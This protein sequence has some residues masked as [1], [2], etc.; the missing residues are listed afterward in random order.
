MTIGKRNTRFVIFVV[1]SSEPFLAFASECL[2]ER[3]DD[4]ALLSTGF[5]VLHHPLF[6]QV[7]LILADALLPDMTAFDLY[8]QIQQAP[9]PIP[10]LII[11]SVD[12]EIQEIC[13]SYDIPFI[14][15]KDLFD[16]TSW[17]QLL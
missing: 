16:P 14:N 10:R 5:A 8:A 9:P 13:L 6:V 7:S 2:P 12:P 15:K 3:I 4:L 1:D 11:M 17:S